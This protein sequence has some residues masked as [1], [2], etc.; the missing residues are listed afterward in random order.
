MGAQRAPLI[1][2]ALID[3]VGRKPTCEGIAPPYRTVVAYY[4]LPVAD[5][6]ILNAPMLYLG[7][8]YTILDLSESY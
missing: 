6:L 3:T 2:Q 5:L 7:A 8:V 4:L 1:G